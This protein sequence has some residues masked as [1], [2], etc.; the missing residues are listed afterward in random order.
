MN[1]LHPYTIVLHPD[2]RE[3]EDWILSIPQL[4]A[5]GEGEIIYKG[6]NELRAFSHQTAIAK[7]RREVL[8]RN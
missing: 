2:F 4:F 8:K 3:L 5:R 7:P 6:R 1:L